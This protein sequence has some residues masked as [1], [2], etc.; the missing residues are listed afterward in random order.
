M[1]VIDF[2][3]TN[4]KAS[5]TYDYPKLKLKVGEFARIVLLQKAPTVEYVHTLRA[6]KIVNG[7]AVMETAKTKKGEEYQ[8][9]TMDFLSNPLCLGDFSIL[10]DKGSDP[11]NCPMCQLAKDFPDYTQPAKRR[12][13]MHVV[14]YKTK[15][16]GR[17]LAKPYSVEVLVWG[18]TDVRFNQIVEAQEEHGDLRQKDLILGPCEA[19]EMFQK[20]DMNV[21]AKAEWL[22]DDSRKALTLETFKEN[23]IPDLSIACGSKKERRWVEQDI[24]SIMDRWASLQ[25]SLEEDNPNASAE[26]DAD[27]NNLLGGTDD[28]PYPEIPAASSVAAGDLDLDDLLSSGASDSNDDLDSLLGE[29]DTPAVLDDEPEAEAEVSAPAPKAKAAAKVAAPK[30]AEVVLDVDDIDSLLADL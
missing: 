30:A 19:P 23:Q 5:N 29:S 26:L 16:G 4:K 15:T 13:A 11:K 1:P 21:G 9:H 8:T 27:L 25:E 20:F 28:T 17:E 7:K 14:R 24:E 3:P 6:P 12:F 2:N 10:E 18:F 22:A